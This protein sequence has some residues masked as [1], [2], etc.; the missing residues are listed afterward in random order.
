MPIYSVFATSIL[1]CPFVY[2]HKECRHSDGEVP[3]GLITDDP[4][5][6]VQREAM[7]KIH[8]N[9]YRGELRGPMEQRK[10]LKQIHSNV[11]Y[12]VISEDAMFN[13]LEH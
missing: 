7:A 6:S 4:N 2:Q 3:F 5:V 10:Y 1:I 9:H 13:I 11:I 8:Y 12:K